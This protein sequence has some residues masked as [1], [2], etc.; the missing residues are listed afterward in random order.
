M[1]LKSPGIPFHEPTRRTRGA[2]EVAAGEAGATATAV[3]LRA[4][5]RAPT[6]AAEDRL[7]IDTRIPQLLVDPAGRASSSGTGV[8]PARTVEA[9]VNTSC[10]PFGTATA[11]VPS[12]PTVPATAPSS[13]TTAPGW[14][15]RTVRRVVPS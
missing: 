8:T 11:V 5:T 15:L 2:G 12:G 4:K 7:P 10:R 1:E 9:Q 14:R 6:S 3:A 13:S